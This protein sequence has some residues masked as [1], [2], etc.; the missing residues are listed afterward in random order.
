MDGGAAASSAPVT[1]KPADSAKAAKA[2]ISTVGSFFGKVR[3]DRRAGARNDARFR[4]RGV[5][6]V[7]RGRLAIFG[8]IGFEQ[9]ALGLG[10]ALERAQLHVLLVGL[11]G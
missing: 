1:M 7:A 2:A 10:L 11:R 4:R 5:D 9:I 8:E 3:L 6:V